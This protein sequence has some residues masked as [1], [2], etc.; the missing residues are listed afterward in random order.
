M[1]EIPDPGKGKSS[2]TISNFMLSFLFLI[3][4][5]INTI[6]VVKIVVALILFI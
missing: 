5:T 1:P 6:P 2:Y 3:K 4:V